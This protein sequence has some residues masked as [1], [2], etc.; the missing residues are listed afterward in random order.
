VVL[1]TAE[2]VC[3][4]ECTKCKPALALCCL[5]AC[6]QTNTGVHTLAQ[7]AVCTCGVQ[8]GTSA[9]RSGGSPAGR[10]CLPGRRTP[11]QHRFQGAVS[12]SQA[13][14]AAP[15]QHA[16]PVAARRHRTRRPSTPPSARARTS[17]PWTRAQPQT[18]RP[19]T[20]PARRARAR[21]AAWD[22]TPGGSCLTCCLPR[23]QAR[24]GF[25]GVAVPCAAE[26]TCSATVNAV[27][28]FVSACHLSC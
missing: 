2:V 12:P 27:P 5:V 22:W 14:A 6:W 24:S 26:C 16:T 25:C 7:R 10:Q 11:A 8:H 1:R 28:L 23:P 19:A 13:L 18:T 15:G 9:C 17:C 20:R 21:R 4:V 3:T